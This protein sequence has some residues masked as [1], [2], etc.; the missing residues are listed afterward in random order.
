MTFPQTR[1]KTNNQELYEFYILHASY[2][3]SMSNVLHFAT[4]YVE[5]T[6]AKLVV[7][8]VKR[9]LAGDQSMLTD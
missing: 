5:H 9:W 8:S 6:F 2:A 7:T 4:K 1:G 3:R